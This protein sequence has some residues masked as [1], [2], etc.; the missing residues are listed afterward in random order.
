MGLE[1]SAVSNAAK[2]AV[3]PVFKN[4]TNAVRQQFKRMT[5]KHDVLFLTDVGRDELWDA[6]LA[7]FPDGTDE[8]YRER[9]SH[10]CNTCKQFIRP[11]GN[12]VAILEGKLVSIWDVETDGY[13]QDVADHM[14]AL[15]KSRIISNVFVSDV[16]QLG[17]ETNREMLP[18]G[19]TKT[20]NHFSYKLPVSFVNKTNKSD[21]EVKAAF[22]D[23]KNVFR[24]SLLVFIFFKIF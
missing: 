7:A 22:R 6:Y 15:V 23:V 20:W 14:S 16:A 4:F 18:T 1:T 12:V 3:K 2:A 13:Y 9:T 8:E 21:A 5:S 17:T 19:K 11:F 10:D 24:R